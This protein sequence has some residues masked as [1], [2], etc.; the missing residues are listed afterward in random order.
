MLVILLKDIH[1][2]GQ[3]GDV[4]EVK[5][6]YARNL[7]LPQKLVE[8]A[9]PAALAQNRA[10][11]AR[12]EKKRAEH[13]AELKKI[14]ESVRGI[15]LTFRVK[16]GEKGEVFGSITDA[17]LRDALRERGFNVPISGK[18]HIKAAGEH[19]LDIDLGDGI[20]TKL[21]VLVEPEA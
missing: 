11:K 7:L 13:T 10:E 19:V 9:T 17:D 16:T 8:I 21:R 12:E 3:R 5:D 6:G 4:K 14:A 20:K 18:H 1:G 15:T 2:L